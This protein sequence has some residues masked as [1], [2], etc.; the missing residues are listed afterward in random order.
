MIGKAITQKI[1]PSGKI[2]DVEVPE[3]MLPKDQNNPVAAALMSKKSLEEMTSRASME[4]P[5]SNPEMGETWQVKAEL[6]MGPA[7][8]ETLTDYT[9]LGVKEG[10]DGPVH[11]IE[12]KITMK[13]PQGIAGNDIEI[14]QQDA[15]ALFFFDGIQGRLRGSELF[16][17]M[18]MRI[19]TAGQLIEQHIVQ[20]MKTEMLL[21]SEND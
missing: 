3:D 7:S 11:V 14:L 18:K 1:A 20:T 13:F 10:R 9:Y 16:Q 15:T 19:S 5:K 8:V 2:F 21:K 6:D 17:D 4:F 12:G